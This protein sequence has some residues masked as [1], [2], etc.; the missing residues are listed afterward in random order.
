VDN[1]TG[2]GNV[3]VLSMNT[4][5]PLSAPVK[6][7]SNKARETPACL[8]TFGHSLSGVSEMTFFTVKLPIIEL[9]GAD[10]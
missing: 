7:E 9:T 4:P 8:A 1:G 5:N 6:Y 2:A 10:T 3:V